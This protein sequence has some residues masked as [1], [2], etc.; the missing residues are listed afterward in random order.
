MGYLTH[1]WNII[2]SIR[3]QV[4][5]RVPRTPS[6]KDRLIKTSRKLGWI[7]LCDTFAKGNQRVSLRNYWH[8][9]VILI[10]RYVQVH[11]LLVS[12]F[13]LDVMVIYNKGKRTHWVQKCTSASIGHFSQSIR[14]TWEV[15][16]T[17]LWGRKW[18]VFVFQ[19]K[20]NLESVLSRTSSPATIHF[21]I[22]TTWWNPTSQF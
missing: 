19:R 20:G 16:G 1:N 7:T 11:C 15:C 8:Q 13:T 5:L 17:N 18:T 12:N 4:G 14:L 22:C 9:K 2:R 3:K 10:R 6:A 21:K